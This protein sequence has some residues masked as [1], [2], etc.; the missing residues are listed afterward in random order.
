[1]PAYT[2]IA[3]LALAL[4]VI[5]CAVSAQTVDT[6][7]DTL[8]IHDTTVVFD[9][10]V[11]QHTTYVLDSSTNY[12]KDLAEL[13]GEFY[14][15][16]LDGLQG[17][18]DVVGWLLTLIGVIVA[19]VGAV[20]IYGGISARKERETADKELRE[21]RSLR[22]E[23]EKLY[24]SAKTTSSKITGKLEEVTGQARESLAPMQKKSDGEKTSCVGRRWPERREA[25]TS[26]EAAFPRSH[27]SD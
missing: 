18:K 14:D 25:Q 3:I 7:V 15:K 22:T 13:K 8:F 10:T 17:Q 23:M 1:M 6:V 24:E 2:K 20:S 26:G 16:A 27:Q 9:S 21:M 11:F 4:T 19:V 12:Q 5:A